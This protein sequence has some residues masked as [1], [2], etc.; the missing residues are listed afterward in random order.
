[1]ALRTLKN[2]HVKQK[3]GIFL[4]C[5]VV[6]AILGILS[7]VAVPHVGQM[8]SKADTK[9][10]TIELYKIQSAV[11]DMFNDSACKSLE[12]IG[13]TSDMRR[14]YTKDI[15]PLVLSDYFNGESLQLDCSYSFTA[16]GTVMQVVP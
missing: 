13:P 11:A 9:D 16:D 3:A 15:P 1:M 2:M 5:F 7:A 12:P 6:M 14:V 8:V 4:I 10:R